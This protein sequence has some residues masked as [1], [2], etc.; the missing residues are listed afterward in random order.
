MLLSLVPLVL[1][2][3]IVAVSG[4]SH[5]SHHL[6]HDQHAVS[7]DAPAYTQRLPFDPL[8][9]SITE[10][11]RLLASRSIT[12]V[13]LV[14]MYLDAIEADNHAGMNLRS[15]LSTQPRESV[16]AI[17]AELDEE[18]SAGFVRGDLHGVPILLKS[19]SR[20]AALNEVL[21]LGS[22][23]G[24]DNIATAPEMGMPTT[25]GSLALRELTHLVFS[26]IEKLMIV[27]AVVRGNSEVVD[28]LI[29][30]GAISKS[31]SISLFRV[32]Q[33]EINS[34]YSPRQNR[35]VG[36]RLVESERRAR[37]TRRV[38][39]RRWSHVQ[40]IRPRR[41]R[42]GWCPTRFQLGQCRERQRGICASRPWVRYDRFMRQQRLMSYSGIRELR[43]SCTPR[44]GP[45]CMLFAR[46]T[47][48]S[49][50]PMWY[51]SGEL[52]SQSQRSMCG[53]LTAS[54]QHDTVG[55]IAFTPYDAAL[56]L[57]T[58]VAPHEHWVD[59]TQYTSAPHD[60]FSL[61]RLG[62][63]DALFMHG[64]PNPQG[65]QT[66]CPIETLEAAQEAIAY[67]AEHGADIVM[68]TN[69]N[70]TLADIAE[71][72]QAIQTKL[73][74]DAKVDLEAYLSR[75]KT[76]SVR[77]LVDLI[78]FNDIHAVGRAGEVHVHC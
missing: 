34:T 20:A 23:T 35:H 8:N 65:E 49:I 29:V 4:L 3:L 33:A 11:Q 5:G 36:I 13:G 78:N 51:P 14:E 63:P 62:I 10:V 61:Y 1:V 38:E 31:H 47:G 12:S 64:S 6:Y 41:V 19:V 77:T 18:R 39:R 30:A 42:G 26:L 7:P 32:S 57:Q 52:N 69:P 59:L 22:L 25:A 48:L 58:I 67:L 46:R 9:T 74:W 72:M 73:N 68:G 54:S 27:D 40:R 21:G 44:V 24:R 17:A 50:R 66:A 16:L 76:S 2:S 53:M 70:L 37:R 71:L 60:D 15:V 75:L 56:L 55:S 45:R 43:G 28:R